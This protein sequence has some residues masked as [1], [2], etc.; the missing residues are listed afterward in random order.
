MSLSH[1]AFGDSSER[2]NRVQ[3]RVEAGAAAAPCYCYM[4]CYVPHMALT[5][6]I[7]RVEALLKALEKAGIVSLEH[8]SAQ[9]MV[10]SKMAV[11][12]RD[13]HILDNDRWVLEMNKALDGGENAQRAGDHGADCTDQGQ[14]HRP[15]KKEKLLPRVRESF[16]YLGILPKARLDDGRLDWESRHFA[17]DVNIRHARLE[18]AVKYDRKN[19]NR[20]PNRRRTEELGTHGCHHMKKRKEKLGTHGCYNIYKPRALPGLERPF[21]GVVKKAK[22][23]DRP[24]PLG[25]FHVSRSPI[26]KTRLVLPETRRGMRQPHFSYSNR[27][28]SDSMPAAALEAVGAVEE[29][30]PASPAS[31]EGESSGNRGQMGWP[32]DDL[33]LGLFQSKGGGGSKRRC[34]RRSC[35][36][37]R[38]ISC[39]CKHADSSTNSSFSAAPA[40]PGNKRGHRSDTP[41]DRELHSRA[42]WSPGS[43]KIRAGYY[44]DCFSPYRMVSLVGKGEATGLGVSWRD[45]VTLSKREIQLDVALAVKVPTDTISVCR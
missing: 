8:A 11:S 16:R 18:R 36:T 40:T 39:A 41:G 12:I 35:S 3:V 2:T 33:H 24:K 9:E 17:F 4:C 5:V 31:S 21:A 26:A 37:C 27:G 22:A 15:K 7:Q 20:R 10:Q 42:G 13:I 34:T 28:V 1:E 44:P 38:R 29:E 30:M 32:N 25:Q 6:D 45:V 43:K 19:P 23:K 14:K